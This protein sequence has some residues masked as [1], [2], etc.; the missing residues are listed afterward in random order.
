MASIENFDGL[1]SQG[2]ADLRAAALRVVEAGLK[3]IDPLWAL[4]EVV[5]LADTTIDAGG[6]SYDLSEFERVWVLGAGK[7]SLRI[8][9]GVES[10]LGDRIAGGLVVVPPRHAGTVQLVE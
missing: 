1:V 10:M 2:M 9:E 6:A 8:V 5:S 4:R 3:A 7:A